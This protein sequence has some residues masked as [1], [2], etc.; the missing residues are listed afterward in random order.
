MLYSAWD[1]TLPQIALAS[2]SAD[3]FIDRKF[4]A[5]Q[6][7]GLGFPGLSNKDAVLYPDKFNGHY[8]LYHRI[9][10]NMWISYL[11]D[12]TCPWPK[13]GQKIV[14]GPR[15]GMMWDGVK[16]GA[17]AQ[18]IRTTKG[19]LNIYHGVDYER[20][21]RLGVLF[22]DLED[23]A[24]V[25]YQSPNPILEPKI[26]FEIGKSK[27]R[28]YWVPHVVF[29]CGAV[30]ARD[31]EILGPHDEILVYYGAADTAI[32]VASAKLKDLVPN[33]DW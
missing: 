22:M 5:W 7:H 27:G 15:A 29:T 31:K 16:I 24:K 10:P 33:I 21:Y 3:E 25:I 4:D 9:D 11:D 23:P 8:I 30:P 28:D 13:T 12:L 6:R 18:P 1:G 26:D 14:V 20:S 32:G 17:G 2:I 19:W